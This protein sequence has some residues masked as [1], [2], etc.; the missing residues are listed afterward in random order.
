MGMISQNNHDSSEGAQ[1][2]V[3]INL[4]R[5]MV[6]PFKSRNKH[7][8]CACLNYPGLELV[9]GRCGHLQLGLEA[10]LWRQLFAL[11]SAWRMVAYPLLNWHSHGK[12]PYVIIVNQRPFYGLETANLSLPA[13]D[14]NPLE[15]MNGD[16]NAPG[17]GGFHHLMGSPTMGDMM[18]YTSPIWSLDAPEDGGSAANEGPIPNSWSFPARINRKARCNTI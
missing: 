3:A 13:W 2:S 8:L 16:I 5:L 15:P 11:A 12:S 17:Y 7:H 1:G 9:A 14:W 6:K 4:P 10:P 18:E